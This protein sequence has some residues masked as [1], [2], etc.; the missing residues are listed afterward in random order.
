MARAHQQQVSFLVREQVSRYIENNPPDGIDLDEYFGAI[1][2]RFKVPVERIEP[3][4]RRFSKVVKARDIG[5]KR[6]ASYEIAQHIAKVAGVTRAK[7]MGVLLDGLSADRAVIGE[8]GDVDFYPD[9]RTRLAAA[10]K[11]FEVFGSVMPA[12]VEHTHEVGDKYAGLKDDELKMRA[13]ELM[14]R[15]GKVG[16]GQVGRVNGL[17]EAAVDAKA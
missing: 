12:K 17:I 15:V 10:G 1:S 11:V 8:N 5:D 9:H 16:S 3:I 7:A 2:V 6:L 13:L 4:Y 14:E